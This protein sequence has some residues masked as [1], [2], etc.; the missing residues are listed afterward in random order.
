MPSG[1][2]LAVKSRKD[3]SLYL[4]EKTIKV[5]STDSIIEFSEKQLATKK[6]TFLLIKRDEPK[7]YRHQ[8]KDL[9]KFK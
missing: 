2:G 4:P 1:I 5:I 3:T 8:Q 6:K 9:Q 7:I